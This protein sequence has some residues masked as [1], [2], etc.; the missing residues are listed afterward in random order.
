MET[1]YQNDSNVIVNSQEYICTAITTKNT[2]CKM[3]AKW[4]GNEGA[5]HGVCLCQRHYNMGL[6]NIITIYHADASQILKKKK[7]ASKTNKLHSRK[8]NSSYEYTKDDV[9]QIIKIQS[10]IRRKIVNILIRD[11]GISVFCRHLITNNTDF[12]E[13]SDI[14]N[15]K[16]ISNY[17]FISYTDDKKR[18]WGFHIASFKE[19]L[20]NTKTNP[21][22]TTEIPEDVIS[23]FNTFLE[24]IEKTKSVEIKKEKI[25]DPKIIIQQKCIK[26][27]Q[28]ID[29]LGQYTQCC[30]FLNLGLANLKELYKQ[31]EDIWNYRAELKNEDKLNFVKDGKIFTKKVHEIN[32]IKSR[33]QLRHILLDD[34]YRLVTEGKTKSDCQTGALW[35][36]S[37]LTIVS[38]DAR[39]AMSWL[40]QSANVY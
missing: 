29:D 5:W 34:F 14:K 16:E 11:R 37:A 36:L 12:V 8:V 1:N 10:Y 21:Y 24:K 25:T 40:F 20:K 35:I 27:F 39:S 7:H 3:K 18:H 32:A 22:S 13:F 26:V 4:R 28:K 31:V 6:E 30:W 15:P 19:L 17:N 33:N 38:Y 2:R 9:N 23:K